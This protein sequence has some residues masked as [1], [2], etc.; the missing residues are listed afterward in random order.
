MN[1][2]MITRRR[3]F[4]KGGFAAGAVGAAIGAGLLSPRIVLASWPKSAFDAKSLNDALKDVLGSDQTTA[5]S[6]ITIK[7]P[8]IAENGAVVPITVSSTLPG[9]TQIAIFAEEKLKK[10]A[11]KQAA[12]QG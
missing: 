11:E 5:S 1:T 9:V 10:E 4:L 6:D 7:A 2:D 12:S 8:D 3:I